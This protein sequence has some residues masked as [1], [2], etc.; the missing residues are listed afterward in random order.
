MRLI[1][2][3]WSNVNS[4]VVYVCVCLRF[5]YVAASLL[6]ICFYFSKSVPAWRAMD[7]ANAKIKTTDNHVSYNETGILC[8]P[9]AHNFC[10]YCDPNRH[11]SA[12]PFAVCERSLCIVMVAN[13][14]CSTFSTCIRLIETLNMYNEYNLLFLKCPNNTK[15]KTTLPVAVLWGSFVA[16]YMIQKN[17]HPSFIRRNLCFWWSAN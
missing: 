14:C 10:F 4:T 17:V 1:R 2:R 8:A 15:E 3:E 5:F 9:F 11:C 12:A 16:N 13:C 7:I 6:L